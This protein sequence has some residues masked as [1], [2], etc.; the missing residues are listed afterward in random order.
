MGDQNLEIYTFVRGCTDQK[1]P[2]ELACFALA[3]KGANVAGLLPTASASYCSDSE[4]HE[5][6][7]EIGETKQVVLK[8]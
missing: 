6:A 2:A 7:G 3:H 5:L 4:P 8:R 1:L